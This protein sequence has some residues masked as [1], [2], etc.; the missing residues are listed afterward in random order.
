MKDESPYYFAAVIL[1]P[2]FKQAYFRDKWKRWPPQ[3]KHAK[4]CIETIF[5]DYINDQ[6]NEEDEKLVELRRRKVPCKS[7]DD[8][9]DEYAQSLVVDESLTSCRRSQKRI[10]LAS[11]LDRYYDAGL[12]LIKIRTDDGDE[13]NDV[14]PDPLTWWLKVG[15]ILYPTLAKIALNIFSILAISFICK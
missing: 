2:S 8:S 9:A 1:H 6:E 3:W 12:E 15:Q 7:D 4:R 11:E 10:K 13:V 5:T 14:V